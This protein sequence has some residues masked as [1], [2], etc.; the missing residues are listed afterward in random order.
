[1]CVSVIYR[2][3]SLKWHYVFNM[4][5]GH[6]HFYSRCNLVDIKCVIGITIVC[7][8]WPF[9]FEAIL[10]KCW[11]AACRKCVRYHNFNEIRL[12]TEPFL[13]LL[14]INLF[15]T[16][17]FFAAVYQIVVIPLRNLK[18]EFFFGTRYEFSQKNDQNPD[19]KAKL[20]CNY[21]RSILNWYLYSYFFACYNCL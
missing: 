11:L 7:Q 12:S 20:F 13:I 19:L 8:S 14:C 16:E 9:S 17:M 4:S 15:C 21:G 18:Q 1:M 6:K 10:Q 3:F 5:E 2:L